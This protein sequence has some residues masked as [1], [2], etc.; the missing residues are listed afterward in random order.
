[1]LRYSLTFTNMLRRSN[2]IQQ[3]NNK[4]HNDISWNGG[5]EEI[6]LTGQRKGQLC[7]NSTFYNYNNE[8]LSCYIHFNNSIYSGKLDNPKNNDKIKMIEKLYMDRTWKEGC[9]TINLTGKR[10]GKFCNCPYY[11]LNNGKSSCYKHLHQYIDIENEISVIETEISDYDTDDEDFI[12]DEDDGTKIINGK[13]YK[14]DVY[15]GEWS[16]IKF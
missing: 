2:R 14:D 5:C 8:K 1:M 13:L 9:E 3:Q 12:S 10:K 7:N 6:N 15:V 16:K 4:L 11:N